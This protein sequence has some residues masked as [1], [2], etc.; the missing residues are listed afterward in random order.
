MVEISIPEKQCSRKDKCV[1]PLGSWLPAI[2]EFFYF[3]KSA[4]DG[5]QYNCIAC[6][7]VSS[8][9]SKDAHREQIREAGRNR[10]GLDHEAI[11][12]REKQYR[13]NNHGKVIQATKD[14][15]DRNPDKVKKYSKNYYAEHTDERIEYTRVY[16]LGHPAQIKESRRA[17]RLRNPEVERQRYVDWAKRNPSA[18]KEKS[19]KR[20]ARKRALP[21]SFYKKDWQ[22]CLEYWDYQCCVC[23]R[24]IGLWHFIVR[25]HWIA[26]TDK[27]VD[28]PGTVPSNIVPM[29][30]SRKGASPSDAGCNNTKY[31]SDPIAW[32]EHRLGKRKASAKIKEIQSYFEWIKQCE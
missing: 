3:N 5:L 13:E 10:R 4:L 2:R 20:R 25:E 8:K 16:R 31:N 1:N 15:R 29:C 32:L 12:A 24:S 26:L 28:N 18:V 21:F 7:K 9:S 23:G 17:G 30:H 27:R 11:L 19:D 6:A 14:W 22:Q